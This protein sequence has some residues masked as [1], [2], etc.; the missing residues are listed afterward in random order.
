MKKHAIE[1]SDKPTGEAAFLAYYQTIFSNPE[2]FSAWE[3]ALRNNTLP[4]LRF[5]PQ[6]EETL[7]ELWKQAE[8]PWKTL[9]WY[10]YAILWPEGVPP[11]TSLPGFEERYFYA[12]NASS[13]LPILAL[14]PGPGDIVLDAC[15]APG[16]KALF[17]DDLLEKKGVLVANDLS[18]FRRGRMRQIFHAYGKDTVEIWGQKAETLF[19][20][21]PEYFDKVLIDAPCSSEKHI[22]REPE[23]LEKWSYTRVKTLSLRQKNLLKAVWRTL[24][25]GGTLV[26]ST[27]AVT[28]EENEEVVADFLRSNPEAELQ[29][30]EI[31]IEGKKVEVPGEAGMSSQPN[32]GFPL[33]SVRRIHPHK[34][35]LGPMFVAKFVKKGS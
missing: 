3:N 26:Y 24:K 28:P 34:D 15:A 31:V 17:I 12:M 25:K 19:Y 18:N 23:E 11:K 20:R 14:S 32:L 9:S 33:T 16:G 1:H 5:H 22:I 4:I 21:Y 35:Q 27:C 2:E 29:P 13:L 10:P 8:L 7:K 30:W 6:Y